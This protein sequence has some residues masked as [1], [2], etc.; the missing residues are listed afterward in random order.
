MEILGI[1]VLMGLCPYLLIR[2]SRISKNDEYTNNKTEGGFTSQK[3][4]GTPEKP[5][6]TGYYGFSDDLK[7][8]NRYK[9]RFRADWA[10]FYQD[11]YERRKQGWAKNNSMEIRKFHKKHQAVQIYDSYNHTLNT[12]NLKACTC[13]FFEP[14]TGPCK[15]MYFFA[16]QLGIFALETGT[17]IQKEQEVN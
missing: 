12:T 10:E 15:H 6:Y 3:I 1:F 5:Y 8:L 9:N 16:A 7:E 2:I 14:K 13:S 11:D 17:L 4:Q